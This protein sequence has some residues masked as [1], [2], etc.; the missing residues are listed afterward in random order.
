MT[1]AIL[2]DEEDALAV[3]DRLTRDGWTADLVRERYQGEDDEE[4]QPWAV[5]SDAPQIM[6][7]MLVEEFDGWLDL[8]EPPKAPPLVLPTAPKRIKKPL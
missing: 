7:E 4:D 3:A 6:V 8:P 2:F 1:R 5:V